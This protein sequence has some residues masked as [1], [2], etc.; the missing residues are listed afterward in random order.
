MIESDTIKLL[1]ECDAGLQMGI[2]SIEDVLD[3]VRA[4]SF[5]TLLEDCRDEHLRLGGEIERQL[6]A[7]GDE[8]KA[9]DPVAKGMSW[10]KSSVKLGLNGS[11][12]TVADL[13]TDG[14]HMGVKSLS[15]YLNQYQAADEYSK[16]AAKKLIALEDRLG[17]DVRQFL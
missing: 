15:R 10:L 3:K 8:G 14:C 4:P 5:R 17:K 7:F 2:S 1:R 12:G 16:D 13:M 9:P 11:D 6:H